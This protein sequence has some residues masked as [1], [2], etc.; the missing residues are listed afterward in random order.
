M[1][2]I[3]TSFMKAPFSSFELSTMRIALRMWVS[4]RSLLASS[5]ADWKGRLSACQR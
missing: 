1:L 3:C 2:S 4:S 5:P